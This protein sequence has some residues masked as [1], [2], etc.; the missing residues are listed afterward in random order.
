MAASWR[1]IKPRG[2]A[3]NGVMGEWLKALTLTFGPGEVG[4]GGLADWW[5]AFPFWSD[6][7]SLSGASAELNAQRVLILPILGSLRIFPII[8]EARLETMNLLLSLERTRSDSVLIVAS[9][10]IRSSKGQRWP[11]GEMM[12]Y[13][14]ARIAPPQHASS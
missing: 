1:Q 2:M 3:G 7:Q 10:M 5:I 14:S 4:R 6:Q 8:P 12:R 9:T 11:G 13:N